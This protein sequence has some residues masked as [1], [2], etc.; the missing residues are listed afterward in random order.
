MSDISQITKSLLGQ[1]HVRSSA[2]NPLLWL[3]A[4]GGLLCFPAAY[5]MSDYAGWLLSIG[6]ICVLSPIPAYIYF[7]FKDPNR[8]QSEEYQLQQQ[9]IQLMQG[10]EKVEVI[11]ANQEL[12]P[13]PALLETTSNEG[14]GQ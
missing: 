1:I 4:L 7:A 10:R 9:Q 13:N 2:L 12:I 5:F 8:L 11:T 6:A 3:A 14:V